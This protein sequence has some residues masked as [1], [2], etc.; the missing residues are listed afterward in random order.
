MTSLSGF[1]EPLE[2]P[3]KPSFLDKLMKPFVDERYAVAPRPLDNLV[4][5]RLSGGHIKVFRPWNGNHV[6]ASG[7]AHQAFHSTL[8]MTAGYI[9]K[10]GREAE[11][12][13]KSPERFLLHPL[14]A[15]H[16]LLYS[17][18]EIVI[19]EDGEHSP[20]ELEASYRAIKESL[21][22][23]TGVEPHKVPA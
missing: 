21:L 14:F 12:A 17:G 6:V 16:N 10:T 18:A 1:I 4:F 19:D 13:V 5:T 20:K 9:A 11:I 22:T 7:I 15:S 2:P 23:F 8:L 3:G